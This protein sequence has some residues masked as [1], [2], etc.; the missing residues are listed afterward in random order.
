MNSETAVRLA[1]LIA[2]LA[3]IT[4]EDVNAIKDA[5]V[6]GPDAA[7]NI[8]NLQTA[9]AQIDQDTLAAWQAGRT[10]AGLPPA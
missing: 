6:L 9:T 2:A 8:Q 7:A 10:A 4:V 1:A 3:A 5:S